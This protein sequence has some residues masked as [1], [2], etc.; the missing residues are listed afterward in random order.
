M[1]Q[2]ATS[3]ISSSSTKKSH[4]APPR[5]Q[6]GVFLAPTSQAACWSSFGATRL[7]MCQKP[8]L[9]RKSRYLH[10]DYPGYAEQLAFDEALPV[11]TAT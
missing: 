2:S 8:L 1:I 4:D 5:L 10:E 7:V 6:I 11:A 3:R 9:Y